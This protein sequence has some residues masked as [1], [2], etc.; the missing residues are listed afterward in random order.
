[1]GMACAKVRLRSV[2]MDITGNE[3]LDQHVGMVCAEIRLRCLWI[4]LV[5]IYLINMWV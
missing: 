3:L 1:M 2:F 5:L 4:S